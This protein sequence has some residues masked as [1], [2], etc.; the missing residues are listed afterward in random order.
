MNPSSTNHAA[1]EDYPYVRLTPTDVERL[2]RDDSPDSRA[3][4]LEKITLGYNADALKERE[5][6]IAEQIFRMLM[7]DVA[8]RV[9]EALSDKL[10]HNAAVPRDIVLHMAN[11]VDSVALPVLS[12]STVLSDADLVNIVEKSPDVAKLLAISKRPKVSTRVSDALVETHYAQVMTTLLNNDGASVSDRSLEK[13]AE[14]FHSDARVIEALSTH[15]RLPITVVERI[16]SQAS[17]DVAARLKAQYKL[18][19]KT[20][21]QDSG[22]VR[23]DL[24]LRMLDQDVGGEEIDALVNQM[25][26]EDRLTPSIVMTS[27]CRGQLRFFTAAMAQY[28]GIPTT[29]AARLIADRGPNGF[30]GLYKKSSLPDSMYEAVY[31]LLRAVQEMQG[32]DAT[33]GTML[34]ANRLVEQVIAASGDEVV[35]HLPYFLALIRQNPNR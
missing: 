17:E 23:E 28:A 13:I 16:V 25:A 14:D 26:Q 10:K 31:V 4:V 12:V 9:R 15:P 24:M 19:E 3:S 22:T 1:E 34:Y 27:L 7:K 32:N 21:K 6:E 11:D 2:L 35:E 29:N 20:A 30:A 18:D 8:L 5:R 33:P